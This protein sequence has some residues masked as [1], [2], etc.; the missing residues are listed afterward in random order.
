MSNDS[1]ELEF[2]NRIQSVPLMTISQMQK[3]LA[4]ID[5]K[6]KRKQHTARDVV[7]HR[8]LKTYLTEL[9]KFGMGDNQPNTELDG[10]VSK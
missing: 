10:G 7:E 1:K 4:Q 8:V 3:R 6:A 2:Q 9:E 5:R